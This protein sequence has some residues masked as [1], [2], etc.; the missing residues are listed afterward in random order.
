[1]T[2]ELRHF[3]P[4]EL[5]HGRDIVWIVKKITMVIPKRKYALRKCSLYI[6]LL[7]SKLVR[8]FEFAVIRC[9]IFE[10]VIYWLTLADIFIWRCSFSCQARLCDQLIFL[11]NYCPLC[12]YSCVHISYETSNVTIKIYKFF[13]KRYNIRLIWKSYCTTDC[14]TRAFKKFVSLTDSHCAIEQAFYV[15]VLNKSFALNATHT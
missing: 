8:Y 15:N 5:I 12:T 14:L 7:F 6:R 11:C 3:D 13:R 9:T 1:M 2:I 4:S 10:L